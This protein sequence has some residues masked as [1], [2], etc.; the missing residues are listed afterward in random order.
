MF[1]IQNPFRPEEAG[2]FVPPLPERMVDT[3]PGI[4]PQLHAADVYV[5]ASGVAFMTAF[6][7]GMIAVELDGLA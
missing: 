2:W 4:M 6:N 5:D 7:T 1:D 3:R